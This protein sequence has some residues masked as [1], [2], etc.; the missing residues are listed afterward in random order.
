M[1]KITYDY[2]QDKFIL[3]QELESCYLISDDGI[4]WRVM[5]KD[6]IFD[7]TKNNVEVTEL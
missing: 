7:I 2:K 4:S 6:D 1:I 3:V 5:F